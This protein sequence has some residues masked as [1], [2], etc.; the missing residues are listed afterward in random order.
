AAYVFAYY[1]WKPFD[2]LHTSPVYTTLMRIEP[3]APT[4]LVSTLLV[5][6]ITLFVVFA[7]RSFPALACVWLVHLLL[8]FPFGG[9]F[10]YPHYTNDRY[11]YLDGVLWS[12]L[13]AA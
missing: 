4:F 2:I 5:A 9:Y 7:W 3:L 8:I 11:A 10:D 13:L 6:G 1:L 12:L